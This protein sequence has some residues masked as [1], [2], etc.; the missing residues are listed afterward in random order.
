MRCCKATLLFGTLALP[1]CHWEGRTPRCSPCLSDWNCA[2]FLSSVVGR[3]RISAGVRR[4]SCSWRQSQRSASLGQPWLTLSP[5]RVITLRYRDRPELPAQVC[6][7]R[8][9]A[10]AKAKPCSR[11]VQAAVAVSPPTYGDAPRCTLA[12]TS[13]V[14]P[15]VGNCDM[16]QPVTLR[17][18]QHLC[19]GWASPQQVGKLDCCRTH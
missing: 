9:A 5:V 19:D 2:L 10:K 12:N 11:Q 7:L 8:G 14:T 13:E 17:W 4:S 18:R 1:T 16:P 15:C 6:V 3:P